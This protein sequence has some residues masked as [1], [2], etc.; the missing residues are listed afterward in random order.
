MPQYT[1]TYG[2]YSKTVTPIMIKPLTKAYSQLCVDRY[3]WRCLSPLEKEAY[4]VF[5]AEIGRRLNIHD[6]PATLEGLI[7]WRMVNSE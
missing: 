6:I 7:T 4:Y 2:K 5:W 3:G 1:R